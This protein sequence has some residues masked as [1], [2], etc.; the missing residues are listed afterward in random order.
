MAETSSSQVVLCCQISQGFRPSTSQDNQSFQLIK[1]NLM[2]PMIWSGHNHQIQRLMK[3]KRWDTSYRRLLNQR[4]K[5]VMLMIRKL[6]T[7]SN[8]MA[9]PSHGTSI[10]HRHVF[11]KFEG[12]WGGSWQL[13]PMCR[14]KIMLE[15]IS[16]YK[17]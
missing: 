8:V 14:R 17:I 7:N 12:L 6:K 13:H 5:I 2:K 15:F 9:P 4:Q 16:C 3:F 11:C 1:P 10:S